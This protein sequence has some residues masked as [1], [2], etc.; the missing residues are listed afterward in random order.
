MLNGLQDI[1]AAKAGHPEASTALVVNSPNSARM[2]P[3]LLQDYLLD[4]RF[5]A[6]DKAL[7]YRERNEIGRTFYR[8]LRLIDYVLNNDPNILLGRGR[9]KTGSWICT[10]D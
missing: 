9:A 7:D 10:P 2:D 5:H 4:L 1:A 8:T 6:G 3:L